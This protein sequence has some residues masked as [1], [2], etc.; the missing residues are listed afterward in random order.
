[1]AAASLPQLSLD[2]FLHLVRHL[3]ARAPA[4]KKK[5]VIT[6]RP[7]GEKCVPRLMHAPPAAAAHA[8]VIQ[9]GGTP[10]VL[11]SLA[12]EPRGQVVGDD[13]TA[14]HFGA[15]L[16]WAECSADF[17]GGVCCPRLQAAIC[18]VSNKVWATSDDDR[19][20]GEG[21]RRGEAGALRDV[22]VERSDSATAARQVNRN[23]DN[24]GQARPAVGFGS[25]HLR[26][27]ASAPTE[28]LAQRMAAHG[29]R[30]ART[31]HLAIGGAG[32]LWW[33]LLDHLNRHTTQ[34]G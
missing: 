15:L 11:R 18:F 29:H 30:I 3:P 23:P 8:P 6:S 9:V 31:G 19:R 22:K 20:A 26:H 7:A 16:S 21:G 25:L 5:K 32:N 10:K 28:Q 34:R 2:D 33:G 12:M 4:Q 17:V 24:D 13:H 1:M 27:S 14:S